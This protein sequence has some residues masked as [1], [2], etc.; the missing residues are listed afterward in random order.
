MEKT[1][2]IALIA[3]FVLFLVAVVAISNMALRPILLQGFGIDLS[4]QEGIVA[5]VAIP[6]LVQLSRGARK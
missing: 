2:S 4:W 5:V 3:S 6:L 1:L